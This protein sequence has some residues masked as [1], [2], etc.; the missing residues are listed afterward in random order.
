MHHWKSLCHVACGNYIF[1]SWFNLWPYS[2]TTLLL[3]PWGIKGGVNPKS[4]KFFP[5]P[6][7]PLLK[8]SSPPNCLFTTLPSPSNQ[9]CLIVSE[10]SL[11]N[12]VLFPSCG[13]PIHC[14]LAEPRRFYSVFVLF[15]PHK[16]TPADVA[17]NSE[18]N[19]FVPSANQ[20]KQ[21]LSSLQRPKLIRVSPSRT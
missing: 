19:F 3:S 20:G 21:C 1:A 16:L 7:F 13:S 18:N 9:K 14:P 4:S 17:P 11:W 2:R 5:L 15:T 8:L 10:F 12:F 6:K